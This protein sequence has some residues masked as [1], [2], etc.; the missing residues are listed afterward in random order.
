MDTGS[1]TCKS[2]ARERNLVNLFLESTVQL[3]DL[4]CM[5]CPRRARELKHIN[6]LYACALIHAS[7]KVWPRLA[8]FGSSKELSKM[9]SFVEMRHSF[10]LG[11]CHMCTCKGH[12]VLFGAVWQRAQ[13]CE[14]AITTFESQSKQLHKFQLMRLQLRA[15]FWST[16]SDFSCHV[17]EYGGFCNIRNAFVLMSIMIIQPLQ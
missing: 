10:A 8:S 12:S 2:Y 16:M 1:V 3:D 14:E 15:V 7:S 13:K 9:W 4:R 6:P 11:P 17:A 5:L